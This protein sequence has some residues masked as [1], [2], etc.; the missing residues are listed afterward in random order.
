MRQE[1]REGGME[2]GSEGYKKDPPPSKSCPF[3]CYNVWIGKHPELKSSLGELVKCY[4]IGP[5][6]R[7]YGPV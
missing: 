1:G 5:R 3:K 4:I 2:G 6:N 7:M